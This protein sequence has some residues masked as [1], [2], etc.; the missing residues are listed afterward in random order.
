MRDG[1][2]KAVDTRMAG[3]LMEEGWVLLDVRPPNEVAKAR[4]PQRLAGS[5][6]T[7]GCARAARANERA[8]PPRDAPRLPTSQSTPA[9]LPPPPGGQVA[10]EGAV[11]VALF[12]PETRNDVASLMKRASTWGTGG[13]WLGGTHMVPNPAFMAEV[14]APIAALR[15][16]AP[17][18]ASP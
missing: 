6:A 18:A 2:V 12:L 16:S 1:R 3:Q 7:R 10:I 8:H 15:A 5:Q 13:W 9:I 4:C 14:R 11:A 17:R